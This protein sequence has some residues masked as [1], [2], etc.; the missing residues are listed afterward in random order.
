ML[1]AQQTV[2]PRSKMDMWLPVRVYIVDVFFDLLVAVVFVVNYNSKAMT[3]IL[4][5]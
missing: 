1:L 4:L 3:R 5:S 2:K